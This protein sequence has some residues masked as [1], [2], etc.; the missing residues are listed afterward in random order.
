[1]NEFDFTPRQR[2]VVGEMCKGRTNK[3]IAR[4]LGM[5]PA[6]VKIHLTEIFRTMGVTSL[7]QAIIRAC[8]T[9]VQAP[10]RELTELEILEEFADLA[11]T[12]GDVRWSRRVV[13]F[14][15]ALG[16]RARACG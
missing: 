12:A 13:L 9:A 16:R 11:F 6:T 5:A 8:G 2:D 14:G 15:Q 10:P 4:A 3:E 1:M 7:A